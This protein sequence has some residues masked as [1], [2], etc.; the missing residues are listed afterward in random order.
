M[1][2]PQSMKRRLIVNSYRT[3]NMYFCCHS[4]V[5][6]NV[7]LL[8]T[9]VGSSPLTLG[10]YSRRHSFLFLFSFILSWL[11]RSRLLP[12][13]RSFGNHAENEPATTHTNKKCMR[14]VA[15]NQILSCSEIK[16]FVRYYSA[17]CILIEWTLCDGSVVRGNSWSKLGRLFVFVPLPNNPVDRY[18]SQWRHATYG[19]YS[20]SNILLLLVFLRHQDA[21]CVS[22]SAQNRKHTSECVL[23]TAPN[24]EKGLA[25]QET[26][27]QQ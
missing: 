8:I 6:S 22:L 2:I 12:A 9:H 3:I 15:G 23:Q 20:Y 11:R 21:P 18:S 1:F 19:K 5:H 16:C 25:Y 10:H 27:S 17:I 26:P 24:R 7:P 13:V 4:F 14:I